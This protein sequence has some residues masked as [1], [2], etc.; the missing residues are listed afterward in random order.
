M[1]RR[2]LREAERLA[3]LATIAPAA[4]PEAFSSRRARREAERTTAPVASAPV[5]TAALAPKI[6]SAGQAETAPVVSAPAPAPASISTPSIAEVAQIRSDDT[7]STAR[8][9]R[10]SVAVLEVPLSFARNE[11]ALRPEVDSKTGRRGLVR[12]K[13]SEKSHKKRGALLRGAAGVTALGFA[14]TIAVVSTMPA[15]ATSTQEDQVAGDSSAALADAVSSV[16]GQ[17]LTVAGGEATTVER[18][19][20]YAVTTM[21][22]ATAANLMSLVDRGT[23]KNDLSATVQWPFPVGVAITD[24]FGPR[25]S[26]GGIGSTNHMGIDFAPAQGTPIGAIAGGTVTSVTPTDNGGLGVHVIVQHVIN[27]QS[28]ESVYGHMLTGSIGVKVGDVVKV[29]DELGKVGNTG[30]STG[31]HLHLEVHTADGNKI[32]PIAFLTQF[33]NVSTVVTMP[34]E[35]AGA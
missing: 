9:E 25:V 13:N 32:D 16:P 20:A 1:T 2:E 23:Y 34:G 15:N 18:E 7:E 33:N 28:Y 5:I 19:D 11:E 17:T 27:G 30:A 4:T 21:G 24:D 26:P 12:V 14:A 22:S 3:S 29:G 31:P 8:I 35:S 10:A 6:V